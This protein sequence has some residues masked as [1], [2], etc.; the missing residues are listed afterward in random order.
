MCCF[1]VCVCVIVH[2]F[3]FSELLLKFFASDSLYEGSVIG[4][5]HFPP[6]F[7]KRLC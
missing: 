7:L 2:L 4:K 5:C 6:P 1:D 3:W